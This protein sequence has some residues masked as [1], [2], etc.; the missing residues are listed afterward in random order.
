MLDVE[1]PLT[2]Q[3]ARHITPVD[4]DRGI[5]A[6]CTGGELDIEFQARAV[7]DFVSAMSNQK[8]ANGTSWTLTTDVDV[9]PC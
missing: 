9:L 7:G 1:G 2:G 6:S 3:F 8:A 5:V 4:G